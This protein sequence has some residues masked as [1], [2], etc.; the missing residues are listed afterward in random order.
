M[1]QLQLFMPLNIKSIT[2]LFFCLAA[3]TF[4]FSVA[5]TNMFL[6][7]AL[8]LAVFSG[9]FKRG[10]QILWK[11]QRIFAY[12]LLFY[13]SLLLL[14]L[15]WSNDVASGLDIIFHHNKWLI[16][17]AL[18]AVLA[19]SKQHQFLFL[20]FLSVGLTLHLAVCVLQMF[21]ILTINDVGGSSAA[22][23]AGYIG[24]ISFGFVYAIWAGALFLWGLQQ[25][26]GL[27]R[28]VAWFMS[29]WTFL[30]IFLAQGRSGFLI[31]IAT[32][33][34]LIWFVF[35]KQK[36]WKRLTLLISFM[37]MA[38]IGGAFVFSDN[39]RVKQTLMSM[40][41][42]YNG[43]LTHAEERVFIWMTAIDIWKNNPFL[44]AGTGGYRGSMPQLLKE[45]PELFNGQQVYS[46]PHQ[47][48]LL[49]AARWG[50]V[51]VLSVCLLLLSWFLI[52]KNNKESDFLGLASLSALAFFV[53]GFTSTGLEA[54]HP[55][56]MG[57]FALAIVISHVKNKQEYGVS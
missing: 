13:L 8:V 47:L 50:A 23:A 53:H 41:S 16:L 56:T 51:G 12:A 7:I 11:N 21:G 4:P 31:A 37:L 45:R 17:P 10:I 24:H 1:Q 44:G 40:K 15:L 57:V 2:F 48:Y 22:D 3:L 6:A 43:D 33:T 18:L 34:F 42:I 27:L 28:H 26:N 52:G 5:A 30:M 38:V 19:V 49:S 54:F 32:I 46:H 35:F 20:I 29:S 55:L 25:R 14:G 39:S 9:D 36:G